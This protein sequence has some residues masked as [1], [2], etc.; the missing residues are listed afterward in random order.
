MKDIIIPFGWKKLDEK[1]NGGL[2][3][4]EI[5]MIYGSYGTGKTLLCLMASI[6]CIEMG[7]KTIFINTETPFAIE[8][9]VQLIRNRGGEE[10]GK[11][12]L[13]EKLEKLMLF[14]LNDF[15]EQMYLINKLELFVTQGVK[16]IVF[17]S[18][19]DKYRES[20]LGKKT[21]IKSSKM[22]NEQIAFLKYVAN[23]N[24]VSI[25]LTGQVTEVHGHLKSEVVASKIIKFW[26]DNIIRLE[27]EYLG[28]RL[29]IEKAKKEV[30]E[31][32]IPYKITSKGIEDECSI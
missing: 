11:K 25:L 12:E 19:I 23:K 26:C 14:N 8:R 24:Y 32:S 13:I 2:Y 27:R 20:L 5:T 29:I 10:C 7:F 22:L 6:S 18:I 30:K 1:L 17:D 3:G 16:L 9:I 28:R 31:I 21:A 4:K 15:D